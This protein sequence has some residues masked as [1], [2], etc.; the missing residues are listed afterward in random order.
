[1]STGSVNKDQLPKEFNSLGSEYQV[2]DA[3]EYYKVNEHSNFQN[4]IFKTPEYQRNSQESSLDMPEDVSD[5][6]NQNDDNNSDRFRNTADGS[7]SPDMNSNQGNSDVSGSGASDSSSMA[8]EEEA[9]ISGSA[10]ASSASATA[11]ASA[12]TT[13]TAASLAGS[14]SVVA[15]AAVGI[16]AV[17]TGAFTTTPPKVVS[18]AYES[19]TDYLTYEIDLAELDE[20]VEYK[21]RVQGPNFI[22]EYPVLEEGVQKQLVTDLQA[23]RKYTVEVV[24]KLPDIDAESVFYTHP[25]YTEK[26]EKPQAVFEFIPQFDYLNGT[27]DIV[28]NTYI[29]DFYKTG[30][31]T[32]F[33][34]YIGK[35][36][37]VDDHN[38]GED[39]F[40]RGVIEGLT[41]FTYLEAT[42]YTTYYDELIEV[43]KYGYRP[44]Y[45]EDFIVNTKYESTYDVKMP[46]VT[47]AETGYSLSIDTGFTAISDEDS[48][49]IDI[50]K[51][52]EKSETNLNAE[53][54][55][56]LKSI[57]GKDKI[58]NVEI[59]GNINNIDVYFTGVKTRNDKRTLYESKKI[60]SYSFSEDKKKA[61]EPTAV[62]E[63]TEDYDPVDDIYNVDYSVNV[64]DI[65]NTGSNYKI[66]E[67]IDNEIINEITL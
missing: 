15:I 47:Y 11:S 57:E 29:S 60:Y 67:M 3:C 8:A 40:F 16:V 54:K 9:A 30:Y 56:L 1:M 6:L 55:V 14:A 22:A 21:I 19:G 17:A 20:N 43:G 63:F 34:V 38:L 10:S 33:Q 59:P 24:G 37:V 46:T 66:V 35:N 50:Y 58:I 26:L 62:V 27:V 65:F 2:F 64:T 45:P 51:G 23:Y 12:S 48:Y 18:E 13:V 44:D 7:K 25:V 36:L 42:V 53:E 49:I 4:E 39:S 41:D 61:P 28:Y 31:N 5:P 32:Y 52:E